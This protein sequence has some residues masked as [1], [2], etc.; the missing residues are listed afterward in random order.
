MRAFIAAAGAW[1]LLSLSSSAQ[2]QDKLKVSMIQFDPIG[3]DFEY[4]CRKIEEGYLRASQEGAD[5]AVTP[6]LAVEGYGS[7]DLFERPDFWAQSAR[8]VERLRKLTETSSTALLL[9]H[10]AETPEGA[11]G[12]PI[13][14]TA[15]AYARGKRVYRHVKMLQPTYSVFEDDRHFEAGD[16]S[17]PW[18]F[19]GWTIGVG[20][21]EDLWWEDEFQGAAGRQV[22]YYET[23]PT[24]A[25]K[26]HGA[27]LVLSLSSSP[28]GRDKQAYRE[29]IHAG[30][31]RK[32][33]APLIW[34]GMGGATDGIIW[35]GRSFVLSAEGRTVDRLSAFGND[36][37]MA[38]VRKN[39][40]PARPASVAVSHKDSHAVKNTNL[41]EIEVVRQALIHGIREYLRRTGAKGFVLGISGGI[42]SAVT[43]ALIA[44]AIGPEN[45]FVVSMPSEYSSDHSRSDAWK[46]ADLLMIPRENRRTFSISEAHDAYRK[47]FGE[48]WKD[49]SLI[50]EN[51]QARIRM[52]IVNGIANEKPGYMAAV[53][54]NKTEYAMGY[55]TFGGDDKGG[56]GILGDL[57][58]MEV[59]AMAR[60]IN[61]RAGREVIPRNTIDKK[62]SA[63]LKPGQTSEAS[64]G[65]PYWLLDPLLRDYFEYRM[66]AEDVDQK[67][68]WLQPHAAEDWVYAALAHAVKQEFKRRQAAPLLRV[69]ARKSFNWEDRRVPIGA[70]KIA[71]PSALPICSAALAETQEELMFRRDRAIRELK[72][73]EWYPSTLTDTRDDLA[74]RKARG[75]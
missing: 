8:C 45:L 36:Y 6:E 25:M 3:G 57:W 30:V 16:E 70:L 22:H 34:T 42:D 55:F 60:W 71:R 19:R 5:I 74:L 61:E 48:F 47:T 31:A 37:A 35:D 62:A 32:L 69:S 63:E 15:S 12:K 73:M 29:R 54:G 21:C 7:R 10:I 18:F 40:N 44:E 43:A 65:A 72:E 52:T 66:S 39:A 27:Q 28:Y 53:T 59:Y 24:D 11:Y 75:D 41:P 1:A 4:N 67:Y 58:K 38:V 64:L 33:G 49:G 13:Q 9:G 23:N 2:A 17:L 20:I 46:L 56:L 14:N 51:T 26:A 68:R 50:D